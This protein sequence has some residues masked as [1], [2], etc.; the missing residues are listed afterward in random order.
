MKKTYLPFMVAM[1]TMLVMLF[2]G[3]SRP[4]QAMEK[5]PEIIEMEREMDIKMTARGVKYIVDPEKLVSG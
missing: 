5:I 4:T 2:P 3:F 1:V